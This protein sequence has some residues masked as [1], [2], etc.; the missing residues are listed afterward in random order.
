MTLRKYIVETIEID[1]ATRK[2][3]YNGIVEIIRGTHLRS[4]VNFLFICMIQYARGGCSYH[5][6]LDRVVLLTMTLLN[7][8]RILVKLKASLRKL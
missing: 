2:R 1:I 6:F 5:D 7:Q 8:G 4:I 3:R